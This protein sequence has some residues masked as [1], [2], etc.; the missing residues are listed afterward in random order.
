MKPP[1]TKRALSAVLNRFEPSPISQIF[2]RAMDLKESGR[3]LFDFST[4]EPDFDT[5]E[6]ICAAGKRA[7][8]AGDT[9]YTSVDGTN[10]LKAAVQRKFARDNGLDYQVSEIIA[11]AG[12]KPLL[13]AA[14]QAI[15]DPGDEVVLP[16]PCWPSHVGMIQLAGGTPRMVETGLM[17]GFK[18][19][20][21]QLDDA[22]SPSTKMVILC[23]PSNPTGATY[24]NTE[25][26]SLA[27][28]LLRHEHVWIVSD[29]LYEHIVF[30]GVR[31]A[32]LAQVE[33]RLKERTLTVN[34]VS[35]GY[36]MTG[37][38]IGFAGGP[39]IWVEAICQLFSQSSG[40]ACSIS[41][42]AAVEALDGPQEFLADWAT[43]Y[44]R[45]RD[46][47]LA[48]LSQATALQCP[49]PD[50]SFYLFAECGGVL[51]KRTPQGERIETTSDFARHL[52]DQW[53]VVV[54]PGSGFY[55]DPYFRMSVAT[56]DATIEGGVARIA[57][58]CNALT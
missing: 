51:D 8:D 42:A 20:A 26:R 50:G 33:P 6:H 11:A 41:Q 34:G 56:D 52:L 54:V 43:I 16:A 22:I 38:R 19:T 48:G 23:S 9:R 5:P 32:T 44:Q 31:F 24:S 12:A 21:G 13:A 2:T 1:E 40:G 25:L 58:A 27:E 3:V 17:T 36:A 39:R 37:W 46:L 15:V 29:D 47:A 14:V 55:A 30:D 53:D 7:L 10:A 57:E 49:V 35:K 18:M 4:G 28:V 45:R